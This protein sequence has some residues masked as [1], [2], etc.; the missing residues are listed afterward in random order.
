MASYHIIVIIALQWVLSS[1]YIINKIM[2]KEFKC[3]K[4]IQILD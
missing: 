4:E 3:E 1:Y 2:L